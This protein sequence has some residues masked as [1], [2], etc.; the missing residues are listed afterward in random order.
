MGK[1]GK[2]I[3]IE[4]L[5]D[6]R[7]KLSPELFAKVIREFWH[8][9]GKIVMNETRAAAPSDKGT[10]KGSLDIGAPGSFFKISPT[11]PA[12]W[13]EVG[14]NVDRAGFRYPW[15]LENSDYY[16]FAPAKGGGTFGRRGSRAGRKPTKGWFSEAFARGQDKVARARDKMIAKIA[17]KWARRSGE[18]GS[19][20]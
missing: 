12:E 4:G 9:A 20:D 15:A 7:R 13:A 11:D 14:T 1:K 17:T 2:G 8:D 3:V 16:H 19:E 5:E 6:A 18:G 10:L